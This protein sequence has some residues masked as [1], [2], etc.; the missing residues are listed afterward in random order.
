MLHIL[1]GTYI[2]GKMYATYTIGML[3]YNRYMC[4]WLW[5]KLTQL[6]VSLFKLRIDIFF[7]NIRQCATWTSLLQSAYRCTT[8]VN[9]NLTSASDGGFALNIEMYFDLYR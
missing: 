7:N 3:C 8:E 2:I 9:F 4:N 5:A 1:S 6:I